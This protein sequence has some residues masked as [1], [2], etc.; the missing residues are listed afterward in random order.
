MDW[1]FTSEVYV[2]Y[3][4]DKNRYQGRIQ[5]FKLG[6]GALIKK[7][8]EQREAQKFGGISCEKS[9][10]YAKKSY[11]FQWR[12]EVRKFLG[13]FVWKITIL[14]QKNQIYSNFGGGGACRVCPPGSA[15]GYTN[16]TLCR[17]IVGPHAYG[18]MYWHS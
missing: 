8:A 9:W 4:Q 15:P 18:W 3:V 16:K 13:Y 7:C 2:S 14:H 5:D 11:F 6:E 10:S 1:C 12:R 17:S